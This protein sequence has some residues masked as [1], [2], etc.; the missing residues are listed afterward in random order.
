ML[1]QMKGKA[2]IAAALSLMLLLSACATTPV[3]S[4]G[5]DVTP[6]PVVTSQVIETKGA[7]P[8][9]AET[10]TI[11]TV[12]GD[13]EVP[14]NP[15]RIAFFG[16]VGDLVAIGTLPICGSMDPELSDGLL[17]GDT[18][19]YAQIDDYEAILSSSPDLI[20]VSYQ[21][22]EGVYEKLSAIAPTVIIQ[23]KQLTLPDRIAFIGDVIGQEASA[24]QAVTKFDD[25]AMACLAKLEGAGITGKSITIVE[26]EYLMG[27]KFGRG[28]NLVY[29]YLGFTAPAKLQQAF[30]N[31]DMYLEVSMEVMPEYC[32]DY[33]IRSVW[34]GAEDWSENAVWNS[35]PAVADGRVL[36]INFDEYAF[37][38]L[39][40]SAKL[41]ELIT[42]S[43]IAMN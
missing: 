23:T 6:T 4:T 1:K 12:M 20:F 30:D 28:A 3:T 33:I 32:G 22:K 2:V 39:Y 41:M 40:T 38:D 24:A 9:E 29:N 15:K 11:S 8:A 37:E 5:A 7:E 34:D 35:I 14:V 21:P 26:G 19:T 13:V 10:R 31:G 42:D 27:E 16:M 36:D 17:M 43:I 18:Y 25:L